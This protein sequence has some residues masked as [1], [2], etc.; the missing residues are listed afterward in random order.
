MHPAAV[1]K[2]VEMRSTRER[3]ERATAEARA[4]GVTSVP[5]LVAP[6]GTVDDLAALR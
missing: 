2:G 4:A 1:M 5:A 3:L 6:D